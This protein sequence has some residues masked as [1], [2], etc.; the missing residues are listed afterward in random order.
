MRVRRYFGFVDLCGFTR[1]TDAHGDEEAVAILTGF[2]TLVRE[3]ASEFGVRVAKWLGD[4]AMFVSTE[5]EPLVA[6]LVELERRI[7]VEG[8]SLPVR[9]GMAG[10]EVI[11]F[12]GDDYI[13]SPVN[14]AARLC[15]G[16]HPGEVLVEADLAAFAPPAVDLR[17]V[18]SREFPGF[19]RPVHVVQLS[20]YAT[21]DLAVVP[22]PALAAEL[23]S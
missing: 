16:A 2:R 10:G 7:E 12:E 9:A 23:A 6:A 5:P 22:G 14:L 18:G 21:T 4:G 3:V 19:V 8:A 13:G 20:V 17:P 1:F 15:D 11:L